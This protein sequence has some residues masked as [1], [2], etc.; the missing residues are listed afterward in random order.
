MNDSGCLI[1]NADL[2]YQEEPEKMPCSICGEFFTSNA[3]CENGHF[4]CDT[5]HQLDAADYVETYCSRSTSTNPVEM[6]DAVM[7]HPNIKMHGPEHH[8]L[9]PAVLLT[10]YYNQTNQPGKIVRKLKVARQRAGNIH[11]GFCGFYGNCGAGV[12]AGIFLSIV[13]E[14]TPLSDEEWRMGNL[15]TSKCLYEIAIHGGPRCCKRDTYIS[16]RTAIKFLSDYL[17]VDLQGSEIFCG[18]SSRNNECKK[19]DCPFYSG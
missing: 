12:G 2:T 7:A 4:V 6:A 3:C 9:V 1:C 5:C 13:L 18:H 19:A 11:G 10:A 16:I 14:T 15:L 8:F 17:Q